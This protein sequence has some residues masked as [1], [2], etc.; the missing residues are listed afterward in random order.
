[1]AKRRK[2]SVNDL[3]YFYLHGNRPDDEYIIE[4]KFLTQLE[5]IS[6]YEYDMR[7]PNK[8]YFIIEEQEND[9]VQPGRMLVIYCLAYK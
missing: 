7:K 3:Q 5:L 6:F 2:R 1:M 4:H 8:D 9:K